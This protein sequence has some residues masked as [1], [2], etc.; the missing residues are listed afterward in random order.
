[1]IKKT[2]LLTLGILSAGAMTASAQIYSGDRRPPPPGAR[3]PVVIAPPPVVVAPRRPV[4]VYTPP[5]RLPV[6]VPG[7]FPYAARHHDTC[8]RKSWRLR[9]F[10]QRAAADGVLT[11]SERRERSALLRDLD[12]TCGGWR[13]R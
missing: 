11:W 5:P 1:M 9:W 2:L 13:W 3:P 4:I 10:E 8:Q 12:R 6:F 7:A